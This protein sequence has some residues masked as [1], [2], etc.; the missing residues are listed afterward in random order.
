MA[1]CQFCSVSTP[2]YSCPRCNALYCSLPCYRSP[3]HTAC[4]EEFYKESIQEELKSTE[5]NLDTQ[6]QTKRILERIHKLNNMEDQYSSTDSDDDEDIDVR[7]GNIDLNDTEKIWSVLTKQERMEFEK[8]IESGDIES[9]IPTFEP[10]WIKKLV[11]SLEDSNIP[12]IAKDILPLPQSK[13]I[14][15]NVRYTVLNV[16]YAYVYAM[17]F[18]YGDHM[19]DSLLFITCIIHLSKGLDNEI[20]SNIDTA[21]ESAASRV[22]PQYSVSRSLTKEAKK[23]AILIARDFPLEGLSDLRRALS[24]QIPTIDAAFKKKI[25][26]SIRKVEFLIAYTLAHWDPDFLKI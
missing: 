19:D 2:K 15:R 22:D 24:A 1:Q 13:A 23:D 12:P 9:Y 4:S 25:K 11:S 10:W 7:L 17:K 6:T 18:V 21:L 26:L 5:S 16:L 14:S 8:S 20:Y 3:G